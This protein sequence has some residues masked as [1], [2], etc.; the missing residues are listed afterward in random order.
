MRIT[1]TQIEKIILEEIESVLK[2]NPFKRFFKRKGKDLKS[3][4]GYR[5]EPKSGGMSPAD[6]L[7]VIPKGRALSAQVDAGKAFSKLDRKA[8]YIK[9]LEGDLAAAKAD[10]ALKLK[11]LQRER[12]EIVIKLQIAQMEPDYRGWPK[13][14]DEERYLKYLDDVKNDMAEVKK[15]EDVITTKLN[16]ARQTYESV[17]VNLIKASGGGT[18]AWGSPISARLFDMKNEI[19]RNIGPLT[20]PGDDLL[21]SRG[22]D[23][24]QDFL[25]D[26]KAAAAKKVPKGALSPVDIPAGRGTLSI[27]AP[28]KQGGL[29]VV[30]EQYIREQI[31]ALLNEST[32]KKFL[33]RGGKPPGRL[34]GTSPGTKH[35]RLDTPNILPPSKPPRKGGFY[36][37]KGNKFIGTG[38]M[39]NQP[40]GHA[41]YVDAIAN[42]A[43][44]GATKA[45]L[46]KLVR[47]LHGEMI[48]KAK[49]LKINR[50]NS[51]LA[52]GYGPVVIVKTKCCG[53]IPFYKSSG[54]SYPDLKFPWPARDLPQSDWLPFFGFRNDGTLMKLADSNPASLKN[55]YG[56]GEIHPAGK[57]LKPGSELHDISLALKFQ[58]MAGAKKTYKDAADFIVKNVKSKLG[59]DS[60]VLRSGMDISDIT[61]T[62]NTGLQNLGYSVRYTVGDVEDMAANWMMQLR[63]VNR[64]LSTMGWRG[65]IGVSDGK[66]ARD[67]GAAAQRNITAKIFT[68]ALKAAEEVK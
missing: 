56:G 10:I 16:N 52:S 51:M 23:M 58:S 21:G 33:K 7:G 64:D 25:K 50:T 47:E 12:D 36:D 49:S 38:E 5:P 14:G 45:K 3:L 41:A 27:A 42:M 11:P 24:F 6:A 39:F 28:D 9:K 20:A 13:S 30:N 22:F 60:K 15:A 1:K 35:G 61:K 62:L 53:E 66:M 65:V 55:W 18:E 26:F 54:R 46:D 29:T 37:S 34:P 8:A 17:V 68:K 63:G 43:E 59:S 48:R 57:Y 67:K 19:F 40:G 31:E 4:P 2:E 32:F 44:K